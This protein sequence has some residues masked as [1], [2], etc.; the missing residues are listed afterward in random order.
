[1]KNGSQY[2][3]HVARKM[4][5]RFF[6]FVRVSGK[7][8]DYGADVMARTFPLL[9]KVVVQCKNYRKPVGVKAVQE[10]ISAREFYRASK[11]IVASNNTFTK[12]AKKLAAKC[13]VELWE[14]Y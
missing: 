10:A 1:M 4:K 14:K 3:K 8:G 9:R 12:N 2:E 11:A 5:R 13:G 7:S 6:L